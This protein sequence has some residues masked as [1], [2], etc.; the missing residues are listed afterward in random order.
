MKPPQCLVLL[1]HDAGAARVRDT[2]SRALRT[3]GI[4]PITLESELGP[5]ALWVD[6]LS[7]LLR[8]VDFVIAD[9]SRKNP[10]VLFELG[11]AHG[12]GKP[13]VL[14]LNAEGGAATLPSDL[15]GFQAL[16]YDPADLGPLATRLDRTVPLVASRMVQLR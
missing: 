16:V 9:V 4:E 11:V 7:A 1:P 6:H 12:L 10:N 2:V 8:S 3:N 5:G 13:I 14:L 15:M